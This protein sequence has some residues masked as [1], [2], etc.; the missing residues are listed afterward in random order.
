LQ[1]FEV[2]KLCWTSFIF[3]GLLEVA[4]TTALR[5]SHGLPKPGPDLFFTACAVFSFL[6]FERVA[7]S[8]PLGT[9]YAIW[10]GIGA[11][12]TVLV[13]VTIFSEPL[14]LSRLLFLG[15]LLGSN[16]RH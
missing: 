10:V 2:W 8:I 16:R 15:V 9:A 3:A 12:G 4:F 1:N 5:L 7:F 13:G 14:G 11:A 6:F